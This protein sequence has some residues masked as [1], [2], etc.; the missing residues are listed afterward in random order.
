MLERFKYQILSII[1]M[2][3]TRTLGKTGHQATILGLGG[4]GIL[5]T[6]GYFKEA[7]AVIKKA[8]ESGINYFDTAP[9]YEQSRDYLGKS[10]WKF[11]KREKIFLASK[12]HER[13][14]EG[15]M[16]LLEDSL[17]KL[18]TNYLDLL[19]LHDLRTEEDIEEIFSGDGAIHALED[20]KKQGKIRFA[21][22]TGH[23][24]PEILT[25]AIKRHS[26]DTVLLCANAGDAHYMPFITT[27]IPE[28]RKKGMG[29]IAMKV[30]AQG[31][32]LA[33]ITMKEAFCYSLSQDVDLAII[34]CKTPQEV[35]EN[36]E[37]AKNFSQLTKEELIQIGNKG[38]NSVAEMNFFKKGMY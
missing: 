35:E 26:F 18:N 28:A 23:H 9:A 4:E 21:G 7:E 3:P 37:I 2:I 38:K 17:K 12:T 14:Y 27:V 16:L 8:V 29:V 34:G 31:H 5:R 1:T 11:A 22:I 20:A 24:D 30:T 19:Q 13:S 25:E 33:S 15:T 36:A 32:A 6:S 10:L